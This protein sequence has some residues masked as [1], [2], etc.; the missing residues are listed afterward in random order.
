MYLCT[1]HSRARRGRCAGRNASPCRDRNV[2]TGSRRRLVAGNLQWEGALIE[3][4]TTTAVL[5][6]RGP[7]SAG[8]RG[9][10]M[11][12]RRAL[13]RGVAAVETWRRPLPACVSTAREE[14][15]ASRILLGPARDDAGACRAVG[16]PPGRRD[17]GPS[18]AASSSRLVSFSRLGFVVEIGA[19]AHEERDV[20]SGVPI[21][22]GTGKGT[23]SSAGSRARRS[24]GRSTGGWRHRSARAPR[25]SRGRERGSSTGASAPPRGTRA[26]RRA[27]GSPPP[28]GPR[29]GPACRRRAPSRTW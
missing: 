12:I 18:G 19:R 15:A 24:R 7:A 2:R 26:R 25:G 6:R 17:S 8:R 27:R 29:R 10:A 22:S 1:D 16:Q 14:R 20:A 11:R 5:A 9:T 4:T 28:R 21:A 3:S 23:T 13:D